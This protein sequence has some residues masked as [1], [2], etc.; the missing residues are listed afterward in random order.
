MAKQ[1]ATKKLAA[2]QAKRDFS[3]TNEPRGKA[4]AARRVRAV[5]ATPRRFGRG[6]LPQMPMS[7]PLQ[8]CAR[9]IAV[10]YRDPKPF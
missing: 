9:R 3:K 6:Q 8:R 7:S 2:Y 1:S 5:T 10:Q 4:N